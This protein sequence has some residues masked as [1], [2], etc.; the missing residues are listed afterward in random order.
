MRIS[1]NALSIQDEDLL[2]TW[3]KGVA[4]KTKEAFWVE[5]S[6]RDQAWVMVGRKAGLGRLGRQ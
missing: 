2:Q 3:W 4:G 6:P 1:Q 5:M